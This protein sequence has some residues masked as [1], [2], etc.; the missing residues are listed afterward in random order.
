VQLGLENKKKTMWAAALGVV[1]LLVFAYEIVPLFTGGPDSASSAQAAA[2]APPPRVTTTRPVKGKKQQQHLENLDPTLRLDLLASSEQ[3]QYEGNGRNIFV[4]QPDVEIPKP[5]A[6][7]SPDA[8]KAEGPKWTPPATPPPQPI[9]LKFFGFASQPGE[10]KRIFLQQNDD[11]WVVGEGEIVN[12]RYKIM[13]I[14]NA[15]VDIQDMVSSGPAQTIP[16]TQG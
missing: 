16:L 9:P 13:H 10:P 15:S 12:R 1:A 3:T 8:I 14:S 2:P 5:I 7:G 11:V 6:P 4:S